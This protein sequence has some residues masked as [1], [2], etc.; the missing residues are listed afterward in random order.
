M[1]RRKLCVNQT[2]RKLLVKKLHKRIEEL[3][4]KIALNVNLYKKQ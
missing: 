2:W 1:K 3:E 4:K